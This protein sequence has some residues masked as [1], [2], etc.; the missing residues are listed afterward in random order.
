[1][2]CQFSP[3]GSRFLLRD[4]VLHALGKEEHLLTVCMA[5]AEKAYFSFERSVMGVNPC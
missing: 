4:L 3:E 1:M 2:S 5:S